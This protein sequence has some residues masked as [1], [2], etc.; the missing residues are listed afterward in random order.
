M[1]ARR[2]R[3]LQLRRRVGDGRRRAR[4][5]AGPR[6]RRRSAAPTPSSRTAPTGSPTTCSAS[7]RRPGP[8]RRALP[9][10]LPRVPRGDARLLQ[11]PGRPDQRQLPLRGRRAARTCSTTATRS[12]CSTVR[13]TRDVIDGGAARPARRARGR[14]SPAPTYD[15]ALA[16]AVA[17]PG[18]RRGDRGDDDH[19]VM[20][21]GGTTGLPKGVV[22]R[23]G[24]AF[25]ACLGGGDPMRM[26]G[27]VSS[28]A[29][30]PDRIGDGITYLP[31]APM[32][33]AAA[34]WTSFMWFF[35]GGKVVLMPGSLDPARVWRTDRRRGRATCSP[36]SATPSPSRCSTRGTPCPRTSAPT[37]S[38]LFSISNGGAPMSTGCKARILDHLPARDGERRLRLVGGRHPGLVAGH[39]GRRP[40]QR[41]G[42]VLDRGRQAH[43]RARRRRP[44]GG[45]R[46]A[47]W[48]AGSSP[49]VGCPLGYY[50]DPEKTAATFLDLRRRALAD[51]RRP[52]HR[53]RGRHG[54][55]ARPRVRVDQHRRREGPPRGG[56]GRA[57]RPPV[58]GRR[59]RGRRARRALGERGHRRRAARRRRPRRP[60]TSSSPTASSSSAGLQGARSTSCSSTQVVRS[61]AGKAD[62]RW[63]ARRPR[64]PSTPTDQRVR[65]PPARGS[66][67]S[68]GHRRRHASTSQRERLLRRRVVG[69]Q[70]E[71]ALRALVGDV[72]VLGHG[73]APL[74]EEPGD[75]RGRPCAGRRSRPGSRCARGTVGPRLPS[76]WVRALRGGTSW[77]STPGRDV[78]E[79]RVVDVLEQ[80]RDVAVG[81][82]H[83]VVRHASRLRLA[84]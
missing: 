31:L 81:E 33:H 66:G 78:D 37:S 24:D 63:A 80:R 13:S 82:L 65:P 7:G 1:D 55:A 74:G 52:R 16:A 49:A 39:G 8:A 62:Y 18:R 25:F 30:L 76:R 22:W 57:A 40:A 59:A 12:A 84:H 51:H 45:A 9:R 53:R 38:S 6:G 21:T 2:P 10:E 79:D 67:T 19:Y 50:G 14:S 23:Q 5:P 20:Y 36:S 41:P 48:S 4:R 11:D 43:P 54:R 44:A 72:P 70:H 61:P 60:S 34:Q 69:L 47:A 26:Q 64:P 29:E 32:M 42:A 68:S 27:E 83:Q 17:R 75:A 56:R 35:C 3:H 71:A 46:L 77:A 58:G 28:P 15:A 73:A